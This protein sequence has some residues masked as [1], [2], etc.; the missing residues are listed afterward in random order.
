MGKGHGSTLTLPI[1][2]RSVREPCRAPWLVLMI[3]GRL[4]GGVLFLG[5]NGTIIRFPFM[6]FGPPFDLPLITAP[7][8]RGTKEVLTCKAP[9]PFAASAAVVMIVL[10]RSL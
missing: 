10:L 3:R 9:F 2:P 6:P 8:K 5:G 1:G 7:L 4:I